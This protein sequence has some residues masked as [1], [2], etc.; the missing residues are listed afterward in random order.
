MSLGKITSILLAA[1]VVVAGILWYINQGY[2]EVSPQG[3]EFAKALYSCC[4]R[5][6][7]QRLETI[8]AMVDEAS[9]KSE[10]SE[11]ET[12]WLAGI[13]QQGRQGDWKSAAAEVRQL[14]L[15]QV[16]G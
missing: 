8:S 14:M 6:D 13:I 10:I 9:K 7:Q 2:G 1:F 3:Y 15:D 12:Q 5:C 16:K 4:N 11:N